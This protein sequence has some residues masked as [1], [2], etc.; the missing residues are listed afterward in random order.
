[1]LKSP[2]VVISMRP[3]DKLSATGPHQDRAIQF[4]RLWAE[5]HDESVEP[6]VQITVESAPPQHVGL[7]VGTQ[8]GLAVAVGLNALTGAPVGGAVDLALSVG[9]GK[10]SAVGVYGFLDGGFVVERGKKTT[11][12]LSPL[13]CQV[14]L[15]DEWRFVLVRPNAPAGVSGES[16]QQVFQNMAQVEPTTP[17]DDLRDVLRN[18]LTP[19]A[20]RGDV[21]AFGAAVS[22]YGR[23]SGRMFS[24]VQGGDYNGPVLH[25]W[26][27]RLHDAGALG[28]GQSSWGPTLYA[29]M[30]NQSSAEKLV[31]AIQSNELAECLISGVENS[32]AA[33]DIDQSASC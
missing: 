10:R 25:A 14:D 1:M 33:V 3:G 7:G 9:R 29:L 26:V 16:E 5:F 23:L 24:H 18:R 4:A 30:A 19:A 12:P 17:A 20:V 2:G 13:D 11:E 31:N 15:P 21:E 32:G 8:L 22:E 28:V 27:D 6:T